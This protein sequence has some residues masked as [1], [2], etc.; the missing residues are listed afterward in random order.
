[1]TLPLCYV[2]QNEAGNTSPRKQQCQTANSFAKLRQE[3]YNISVAGNRVGHG[4]AML[5]GSPSLVAN[6]LTEF[7]RPKP[8]N[9]DRLPCQT[10]PAT[11]PSG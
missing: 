4:S 2:S 9:A 7:T 8:M 11:G 10:W 3:A 5:V 6:T 1:M